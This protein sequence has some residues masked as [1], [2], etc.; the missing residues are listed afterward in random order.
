[1]PHTPWTRLMMSRGGETA[2][3][4]ALGEVIGLYWRPVRLCIERRGFDAHESE[5]LT[6]EFLSSL[7]RRDDLQAVDP[8]KGRLRSYLLTALDH[9]LNNVRRKRATQ[10][11]GGGIQHLPLDEERED[12]AGAVTASLAGRPDREFDRQWALALLDHVLND[13]R[14]DYVAQ[15]KGDLFDLLQPALT[16]GAESSETGRLAERAGLSE[17]AVR[18]AVHRLRLRYRNLLFRHVAATVESEEQVESEI[19]EM[20]S[21]LRGS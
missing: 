2:A 8:A 13:L 12:G 7:V 4:E 1:M 17:G 20:I 21:I 3:H 16:G 15:G 9:F 19:R 6:Q 5:D 14:A 11:R 18:V 10:R